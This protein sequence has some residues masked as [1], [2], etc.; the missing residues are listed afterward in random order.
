LKFNGSHQIFYADDVNILGGSVHT[1][2]KNTEAL[3]AASREISLEVNAD[4][5]KYMVMSRDQNERRSHNIKIANSSFESVEELQY[6]GTNLTIK[7][8]FSKK[9]K[10]K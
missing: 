1:I 3:L 2:K 8:L 10:A 5:P 9:L 6:L 7:I 4:K